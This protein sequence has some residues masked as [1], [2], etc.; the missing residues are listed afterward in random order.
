MLF[1]YKINSGLDSE[2]VFR[3]DKKVPDR[4]IKIEAD[5]LDESREKLFNELDSIE[6]GDVSSFEVS[7]EV[8]IGFEPASSRSAAYI[9]E[10]QIGECEFIEDDGVWTITHTGVR[11]EFGGRGIAGLLVEKV[12]DEA[13]KRQKKIRP[14]CSYAAKKMYG[15]DEYRDV[16]E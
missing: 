10:K 4:I 3:M 8:I 1:I 16:L 11:P 13:R 9:D 7:L 15:K 2:M 5:S 12:I 14:L 6:L